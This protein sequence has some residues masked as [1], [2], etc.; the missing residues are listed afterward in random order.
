MTA[1]W[2]I[3]TKRAQGDWETLSM[4]HDATRKTAL[5][6]YDYLNSQWGQTV[7]VRAV[8]TNQAERDYQAGRADNYKR[9]L[10]AV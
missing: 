10:E 4:V 2:I 9:K 7:K 6:K 5:A 1:T 3:Q 8:S